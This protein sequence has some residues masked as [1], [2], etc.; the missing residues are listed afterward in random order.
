MKKSGK[1]ESVFYKFYNSRRKN[2]DSRYFN[3][4]VR[5]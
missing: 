4:K 1:D 3:R 2:V 5:D